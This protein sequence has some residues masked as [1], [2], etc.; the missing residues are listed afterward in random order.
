M[1]GFGTIVEPARPVLHVSSNLK[2]RRSLNWGLKSC[3]PNGECI[4]FC[5]ARLRYAGEGYGGNNGPITSPRMQACYDRNLRWLQQ[6]SGEAIQDAAEQLAAGGNDLRWN[7]QG[8]LIPEALPLLEALA[9]LGCR[10]WGFSRKPELLHE[11]AARIDLLDA[12]GCCLQRPF[13]IGSVDRGTSRKDRNAL[14]AATARLNGQPALAVAALDAIDA[15]LLLD[16]NVLVAF[17]YHSS[18]KHTRLGL[19][20]ECPATAG[21]EVKCHECRRCMGE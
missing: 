10:S 8:D 7:G 21:E 12:A 4:K 9:G 1:G 14:V 17:G 19:R 20:Q 5:Y 13:F 2:A 15:R 6:A 16:S 18:H 3:R 11:L